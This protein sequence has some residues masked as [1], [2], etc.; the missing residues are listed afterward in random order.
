MKIFEALRKDHEKQRLLLK[1]LAETSGDTAARREYFQELKDQLESHA[2][3]EERHFY[4]HMLE[5]DETVELT[6]HG[7]AEHH[8]IDELIE[9]LDETEMSSPAWLHYLKSLQEKVEHHLADEEQ[10]FF[11]VVGKVLNERQKEK[12]ADGYREEMA[13]ELTHA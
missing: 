4:S 10:E 11:Q 5:N 6:R 7:I 13:Q 3:A 9:K 2:V 12:L 1:I 8:E